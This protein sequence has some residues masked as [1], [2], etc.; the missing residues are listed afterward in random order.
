MS[1]ITKHFVQFFHVHLG[2]ADS[3]E[4]PID[5]WHVE[6]ACDMARN[7]VRDGTLRP[8]GFRFI[9]RERGPNDLDSKVAGKSQMYYLGGTVRT[10]K[11][12]ERDNRPDEAVMRDNIRTNGWYGVVHTTVGMT[13]QFE[14]GDVL[15]AVP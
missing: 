5:T 3:Y 11:D 1:N 13:R 7:L 2:M 8:F 12:V 10:L 6:T 4:L 15:L 9:T 14:H